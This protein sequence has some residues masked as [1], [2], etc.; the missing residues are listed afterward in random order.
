MKEENASEKMN[1]DEEII[2][3]TDEVS[4]APESEEEIIELTE[5][6][7][8]PAA[9]ELE[10]SAGDDFAMEEITEVEE[11]VETPGGEDQIDQPVA[12]ASLDDI[13]FGDDLL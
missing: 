9:Q 5:T 11:T 13:Q 4:A 6:V 2:D 12:E 3:L 7:D 10:I 8:E 1:E